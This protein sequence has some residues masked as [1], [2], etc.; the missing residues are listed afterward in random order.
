MLPITA[1]HESLQIPASPIQS[2]SKNQLI[3]YVHIP[4]YVPS[5]STGPRQ[6]NGTTPVA[7]TNAIDNIDDVPPVIGW[8]AELSPQVTARRITSNE[9]TLKAQ[10]ISKVKERYPAS[11]G[12]ED[13]NTSGTRKRKKSSELVTPAKRSRR[14]EPTGAAPRITRSVARQSQPMTR[15]M[16]AKRNA[17]VTS[18]KAMYTCRTSGDKGLR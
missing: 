11:Q 6:T 12:A 16:A 7:T 9:I 14:S 17:A 4:V 18:L 1:R 2:T 13:Q 10:E 15:S 5:I 3:S 8:D